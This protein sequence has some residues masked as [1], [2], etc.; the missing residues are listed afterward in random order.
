MPSLPQH[1]FWDTRPED[2]DFEKHAAWI[3]KRVLE[4]GDWPDW[5]LLV[6]H[7]GRERL[8]NIV[9]QIRTLQPKSLAFCE[10]WFNLPAS[11]FR[12]STHPQFPH[13]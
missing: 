10:A 5:Q 2:I 13:P 7:Y 8:A 4:Y 1:L 3:A 12:C 9:T 11:V 6:R